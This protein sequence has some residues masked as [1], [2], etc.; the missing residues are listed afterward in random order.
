MG[1]YNTGDRGNIMSLVQFTLTHDYVLVGGDSRATDI[2]TNIV[3]ETHKKVVKIENDI[4]IGCSGNANDA[5][6]LLS[7]YCNFSKEHGMTCKE[8]IAISYL[9]IIEELNKKYE[10]MKIVHCD[11]SDRY[12]DFTVV[13]CGY[14]GY[15]FEAV[16]YCLS[17]DPTEKIIGIVPIKVNEKSGVTCFLIGSKYIGIHN[18][19]RYD[20]LV[21]IQPNTILQH[22]NV[23]QNVFDKGITFDNTINNRCV[24][25][26]IKKKYFV[27]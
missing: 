13:V 12:F 15:D 9:Q 3:S 21:N 1:Y 2:N 14:N 7:K 5:Y 22:K 23:M 25:E 10:E 4:I 19:N 20:E 16:Q 8:N 6:L 11:K 26:K 24:Y 27:K 18:K 17:H